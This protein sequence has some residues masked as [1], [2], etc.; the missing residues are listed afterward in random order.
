MCF[1]LITWGSKLVRG[2]Y[3][4]RRQWLQTISQAASSQRSPAD[5]MKDITFYITTLGSHK[6]NKSWPK[7]IKHGEQMEGRER[8]GNRVNVKRGLSGGLRGEEEHCGSIDGLPWVRTGTWGGFYWGRSLWSTIR[9]PGLLLV[10]SA[11][12][13]HW[14]WPLSPWLPLPTVKTAQTQGKSQLCMWATPTD[15]PTLHQIAHGEMRWHSIQHILEGIRANLISRFKSKDSSTMT[16]D[17]YRHCLKAEN[18]WAIMF[19]TEHLQ[20][21][22]L[23]WDWQKVHCHIACCVISRA[24]AALFFKYIQLTFQELSSKCD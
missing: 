2:G 11:P 17:S 9:K 3:L 8:G 16:H 13:P 20:R 21:K 22:C 19:E 15:I 10:C 6:H 12:E 23:S 1:H 24:A 7:S 5:N 14:F 4:R 18:T